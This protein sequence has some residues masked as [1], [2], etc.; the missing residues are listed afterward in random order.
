MIGTLFR[1]TFWG[2]L[3]LFFIPVNDGAVQDGRSVSA[4]E[5]LYAAR[6]TM[7]DI[8]GICDRKPEVCATGGAALETIT[9]RA[10]AGARIVLS[11]V[12]EETK[13]G[14]LN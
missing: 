12:D 10:K 6:E 9:E 7:A 5:A 1:L 3:A 2:G 13:T 11:Y 14:S 8:K 4:L